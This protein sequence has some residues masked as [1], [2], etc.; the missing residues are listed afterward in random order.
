MKYK[1]IK[2]KDTKFSSK[3]SHIHDDGLFFVIQHHKILPSIACDDAICANS[4]DELYERFFDHPYWP[5]YSNIPVT[6]EIYNPNQNGTF[7]LMEKY[8]TD[9]DYVIIGSLAEAK[10]E[11]CQYAEKRILYMSPGLREV[12][13]ESFYVASDI[14]ML[15][16]CH[17]DYSLLYSKKDYS[18]LVGR[19]IRSKFTQNFSKGM[20]SDRMY[21]ISN[22]LFYITGHMIDLY[23]KSKVGVIHGENIAGEILGGYRGYT[24]INDYPKDANPYYRDVYYGDQEFTIPVSTMELVDKETEEKFKKELFDYWKWCNEN[25]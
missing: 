15:D 18:Y 24:L 19:V 12:Y 11:L 22:N 4:I 8:N 7:D 10:D 9:D 1:P 16:I 25:E 5:E 14:K 17:F 6:I 2:F 20:Y 23:R 13:M 3:V 21:D